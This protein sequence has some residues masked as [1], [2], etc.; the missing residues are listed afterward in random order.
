MA[1][2]LATDRRLSVLTEPGAPGVRADLRP[3][4]RRRPELPPSPRSPPPPGKPATA[5][6]DVLR[7]PP[8]LLGLLRLRLGLRCLPLPPRGFPFL[9]AFEH[10]IPRSPPS[11]RSV[12]EYGPPPARKWPASAAGGA[13]DLFPDD[14]RVTG[15]PGGLAG[16]VGQHRAQCVPVAL[17]RDDEA[18]LGVAGGQDGAVAV[19]LWRPGSPGGRRRRLRPAG[20]VMPC[21]RSGSQAAP[22]RWWP[23]QDRSAS[24]RCWMRPRMDVPLPT[25]TRRNCSPDSPSAFFSTQCRA[26]ERNARAVPSSPES[27]RGTGSRCVSAMASP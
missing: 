7:R 16:H 18:R 21:S 25:R 23:N 3:G 14:V 19:L 9:A 17:D 2:E 26:N 22:A 8:G 10:A 6:A 12:R 15:V 11:R 27:S 24:V 13:V 4:S 5:P 20:T 1:A